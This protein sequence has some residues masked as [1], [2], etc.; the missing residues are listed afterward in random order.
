MTLRPSSSRRRSASAPDLERRSLPRPGN[1]D[2]LSCPSCSTGRLEFNERWRGG[3][4][5]TTPAW[6]CDR[7]RHQVVV[8][9]NPLPIV[10]HIERTLREQGLFEALRILNSTTQYRFTGVY[11]FEAGWVKSV[12]LF[13]RKNPHLRIGKDVPW[14]DSYCRLTAED[15]DS[16]RIDSALIDSRLTTHAAREAVQSYIAVLL[17]S[18]DGAPFGTLCHFDVCSRRADER[19]IADLKLVRARVERALQV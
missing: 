6:T 4:E 9:S 14:D 7:C 19:T 8:R 1:G 16:C 5:P 17:R 12:A 3:I 15:G 2:T 11:R 10:E 18:E 13:D